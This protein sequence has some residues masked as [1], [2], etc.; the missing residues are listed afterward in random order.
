[1]LLIVTV[2]WASWRIKSPPIPLFVQTFA[3]AYSKENI[4]DRP[5]WPLGN[6][7]FTG[8]FPSGS[9]NN[10]E[11]VSILWRF[12]VWTRR[13]LSITRVDGWSQFFHPCITEIIHSCLILI[14][15]NWIINQT[16]HLMNLNLVSFQFPTEHFYL[17]PSRH[18]INTVVC[19]YKTIFKE[20]ASQHLPHIY[21]FSI[22]K[23]TFNF[24][25]V[26]AI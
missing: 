19:S 15:M 12:H 8:G 24:R 14:N 22:S 9:P 4:K 17:K 2:I 16:Y 3:P 25:N 7:L 13:L 23:K 20:N 11:N 6:T 21:K 10:M 1:M 5:Y 26:G 18:L